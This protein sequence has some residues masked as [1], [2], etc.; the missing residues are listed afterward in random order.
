VIDGVVTSDDSRE[1]H[2]S[3]SAHEGISG[4][5]MQLKSAF[6]PHMQNLV[7]MRRLIAGPTKALRAFCQDALAAGDPFIVDRLARFAEEDPKNANE[8]ECI[9]STAKTQTKFISNA[10]I[11]RNLSGTSGFRFRDI[12][13]TPTACYWVLPTKYMH[14]CKKYFRLGVETALSDLLLEPE[15]GDI[16][17]LLVADEFSQW[18]SGMQSMANMMCLG[19]GYKC[20]LLVV[21]QDLVGLRTAFREGWES[22]LANADIKIFF[23]PRDPLSAEILSKLSGIKSVVV[24][25]KATGTNSSQGGQNSSSGSTESTS[26]SERE[27]PLFHPFETMRLPGDESL[28]IAAGVPNVIRAGRTPYYEMPEFA[29]CYD[30]DPYHLK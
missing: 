12:R 9:I 10:A 20:Q 5:T 28:I 13:K 3:E 23:A 26:Y 22:F 16:P 29:G 30:V 25:S 27:R 7:E 11:A 14:S 1:K 21:V 18:G 6:L 4:T 24:E 15:E 19:R 17:V 8:I 2:W